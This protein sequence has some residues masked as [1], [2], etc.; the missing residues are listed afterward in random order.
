M[1]NIKPIVVIYLNV[2]NLNGDAADAVCKEYIREIQDDSVIQYI[3]PVRNKETRIEVFQPTV[4]VESEKS[5]LDII[6]AL[7][8]KAVKARKYQL[9]AHLR[10]AEKELECP[11]STSRANTS[12]KYWQVNLGNE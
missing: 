3:I 7:K 2:G 12:I 9:A 1:K 5:D 11:G 8:S 10:E 6:K 4:I